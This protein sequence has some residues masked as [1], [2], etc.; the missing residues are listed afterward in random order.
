VEILKRDVYQAE[1]QLEKF[2]ESYE[3]L[4]ELYLSNVEA[5]TSTS[6]RS[7]VSNPR[8]SDSSTPNHSPSP[9][10]SISPLQQ[11]GSKSSCRRSLA[12]VLAVHEEIAQIVK[13]NS[14]LIGQFESL[15]QS[16]SNVGS[17]L[18]S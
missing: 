15:T 8:K 17:S 13:E 2:Q 11:S 4:E 18:H 16:I 6:G 14:E 12:D 9:T 5:Q 3:I 10:Q 1:L 7:S